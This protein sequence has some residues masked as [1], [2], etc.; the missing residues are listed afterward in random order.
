MKISDVDSLA[1][2]DALYKMENTFYTKDLSCHAIM[3]DAHGGGKD[4]NYHAMVGK[5]LSEHHIRLGIDKSSSH[6]S[7]Y[8]QSWRKRS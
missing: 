1:V 8:G 3:L 7:Y 6:H 5:Y 2:K 4:T